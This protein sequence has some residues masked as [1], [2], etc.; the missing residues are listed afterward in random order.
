M[1]DF[2]ISAWNSSVAAF[3]G[4]IFSLFGAQAPIDGYSVAYFEP[5]TSVAVEEIST[6]TAT[7]SKAQPTVP[8]T[9]EPV[10]LP[11]PDAQVAAA[12]AATT[13]TTSE[14]VPV[15][16]VFP[17]PEGYDDAKTKAAVVNIICSSKKKG[18]PSMTGSGV[19]INPEGIILTNAHVG[20]YFLLSEYLAT[21]ELRCAIRG[22]N[23]A[24]TLYKAEIL[25]ISSTWI[26]ENSKNIIG[27]KGKGTGENDFSLLRIAESSDGR[28]L[29]SP[30]PHIPYSLTSS[31]KAK[32]PAVIT[33][34][35]AEYIPDGDISRK[36]YALSAPTELIK[37][38]T[39]EKT[40]TDLV[41][42][43]GSYLAQ[44]GSSGGALV[45]ADGELKGIIS[46]ASIK[47]YDG[48][49]RLYAITTGHVD[50]VINRESEESLAELLSGNMSRK[51]VRFQLQTAPRLE[52]LLR[53]SIDAKVAGTSAAE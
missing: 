27:V 11:S 6:A 34:Y 40:T 23:P 51:A 53:S 35:P 36:L 5:G 15:P 16:Q 4:V 24:R 43:H 47:F 42:L 50:R 31:F 46:T 19:V 22:G 3:I 37:A 13:S 52:L 38:Y 10:P 32:S 20:Q 44:R 49:R 17:Y 28:A 26:E 18:L 14:E 9:D 41:S 33:A 48:V 2:L 21:G 29:P 7:E 39:F 8:E 45:G 1:A 12:F 30:F 25:Y